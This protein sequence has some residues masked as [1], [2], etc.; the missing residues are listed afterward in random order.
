MTVSNISIGAGSVAV[1]ARPALPNTDSTSGKD[2]MMRSCCCNSSAALV[3]D[4]PGNDEGM[5][6]KVPSLRVG[7]NSL[8]SRKA[9]HSEISMTATAASRVNARWRRTQRIT[10]RYRLTSTRYASG[11][12][13]LPSWASS[14]NTGRNDTV[15]ISRLKNSAGPTSLHAAT[16]SGWRGASAPARSICLCAFSTITIAASTMAPMAIAI[17]D[18]LMILEFSPNQRMARNAISTAIGNMRMATSALRTWS[19]NN[20]QTS[21]TIAI[22]S[23][24]VRFRVSMAR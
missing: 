3:T 10:G 4:M 23:T 14:V 17:P 12:N 13:S 5:Y 18:R 2:L 1:C 22:S 19:R 15:M 24:R 9:G 11:W 20:T 16:I 21:A 7:M 8:P 6:S